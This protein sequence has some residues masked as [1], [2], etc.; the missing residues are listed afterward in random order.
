MQSNSSNSK[1]GD[2][3]LARL[4]NLK[5]EGDLIRLKSHYRRTIPYKIQIGSLEVFVPSGYII[6]ER[7]YVGYVQDEFEDYIR[8]GAPDAAIEQARQEV[9]K[10]RIEFYNLYL[11]V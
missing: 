10:R 6:L 11:S 7:S 2:E 1:P 3:P 8:D 9:I 4:K 5:L